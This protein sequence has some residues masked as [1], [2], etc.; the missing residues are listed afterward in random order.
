MLLKAFEVF[1]L[2]YFLLIVNL[3]SFN[4]QIR[5][6]RDKSLSLRYSVTGPGGDQP[7]IGVFII[8][9]ISGQLSVTKPLDREQIASFHVRKE[10]TS[11]CYGLIA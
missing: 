9:P 7:P 8:S 2:L 4:I 6:D 10:T 3:F 5:S 11:I 1:I